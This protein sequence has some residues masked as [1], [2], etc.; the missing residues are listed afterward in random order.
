[1]PAFPTPTPSAAA[2]PSPDQPAAP[3]P[4]PESSSAGQAPSLSETRRRLIE[5]I[6]AIFSDPRF[7][8]AFWGVIVQSEDGRDTLYA[9][10]PN[11]S[12]MPA[13][14][15]KLLTTAAALHYLGED[16]R[17]QTQL[18]WT[19]TL[20]R[21]S[22]TLQG[23]LI[24]AGSGDPTI[25]GRYRTDDTTTT[26]IL[27]QWAEAVARLGV[28][29]VTGSVVGDGSYFTGEMFEPTWELEDVPYWYATGV[30]ALAA[31]DN[32]FDFEIRP[33]P[34]PGKPARI[35]VGPSPGFITV[36]NEV[37]TGGAAAETKIDW[38]RW[39]ESNTVRF[40]GSIAVNDAPYR[41]FAALYDGNRFTAQLFKERLEARGIVVEGEAVGRTA[42]GNP[43]VDSTP[44]GQL[45][46]THLSPPLREVVAMINKPSQNF[47]ADMLVRT[48]GRIVKGEG[49]FARG[50]EAVRD[51]L[52]LAGAPDL[53]RL[54]L[55]DGSGLS[56]R[57]LVQPNHLVAVLTYAARQSWFPA[58]F[59][60]LP[61]AG[62]EGTL[63]RRLP[64]AAAT[65]AVRAKT[66]TLA[67][68]RGL[69][70]YVTTAGGSRL[71]FVTLANHY[72]VTHAEA[73]R[74]QDDLCELLMTLRD[75]DLAP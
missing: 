6:D 60:S 15:T 62:R 66:G 27:D 58:F 37:V 23:D 4:G 41:H 61:A 64:R 69:S 9:R 2:L 46:Y 52:A 21:E 19:G 29:R 35:T 54:N 40:F 45:I 17:W 36:V 16:F 18:F 11:K 72:T 8:N 67:H 53:E 24:I 68:V 75:E 65:G 28:R 22:G 59:E 7:R 44:P 43:A 51:F 70:G 20:E 5:R 34:A 13:S 31:N 3:S 33:G 63:S 56:R 10:N 12:F 47:Y 14:N 55:R 57:N 38:W 1:M 25:S 42:G 39:P 32:C 30:T 48:L 73:G 71:I 49:S 74:L 26:G 50:T